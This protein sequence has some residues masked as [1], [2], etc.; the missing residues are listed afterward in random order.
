MQRWLLAAVVVLVACGGSSGDLPVPNA[1]CEADGGVAFICGVI[2]PEDVIAVPGTNFIVASGYGGGG[3]IHFISR[4]D[5]TRLQVYPVADPRLRHDTDAYPDCPGPIDPAEGDQFNA[6]GLNLRN[7]EEGLH[8]L[9]VVHHGFR[10][11][12]E[13]FEIDTRDQDAVSDSPTPGFAWIG[14]V[15]APEAMT[16]NSVSPLPGGGFVV[17]APFVPAGW[18]PP[19]AAAGDDEAAADAD[20]MDEAEEAAAAEETAATADID[21]AGSYGL[22]WEWS[23]AG[24]WSIVP[25]SESAGPNGIEAS[26]DGE[27]LY[28]NLWA[29]RQVLR[30]SRGRDPVETQVADLSFHPDNIRWQADGTLLTAG[31]DAPDLLARILECIGT[32]C[33][34]MSS[35]VAR[36]D[37]D[38]LAVENVVDEPAN[39]LFFTATAALQVDDEIWVG[40][41]RGDRIARYPIE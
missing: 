23:P 4:R 10:E 33:D 22:V 26:A 15:I 19:G 8:H 31:H 18:T 25:G 20:E 24:G 39:E 37:P 3:G 29:G 9:Y 11:S 28:V 2:N 35:N 40:S 30:L 6:H 13:I 41:V 7:V 38:T 12:I 21:I 14:C 36:V 34:G 32:L 1:D 17:T 5:Q 16:L 27:W